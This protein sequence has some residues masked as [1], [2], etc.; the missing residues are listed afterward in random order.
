MSLRPGQA[1]FFFGALALEF[2]ALVTLPIYG[3]LGIAGHPARFVSL[4][5]LA[6]IGYLVAVSLYRRFAS[7]RALVFWGVAILLRVAVFSAPPGDDFWRYLWEGKIQLRG[8]NPYLLNPDHLALLP[9]RDMVWEKINHRDFAAIYPPG[10]ELLFAALVRF[11]SSPFVFKAVFSLADLA[12]CFFLVQLN[13]GRYSA[14]VW[15]AWHPAVVYSFAGAAHFDSL[16]I[17]AL[18]A[19]MMAL[20]RALAPNEKRVWRW[21]IFSAVAL[22]LAIALKT[23]PIFLLPVW[24]FALGR[25]GVVLIISAL[26]PWLLS[27]CYGGLAVVSAPL[28]AFA[29]VTRFND[30]VWWAIDFFWVDP[31]QQNSRYEIILVIA[32]CLIAFALRKDWRRAALWVLGAALLLSP[33]LHPWYVTW[34][35]PLACWRKAYAWTVLSLSSVI[36][37]LVWE[38]GPFW[39]AWEMSL[40]LRLLILLPPVLAGFLS[41]SRRRKPLKAS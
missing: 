33:V 35:L 23:V 28:A 36:A 18:A 29:R 12:T 9:F 16:M 39:K 27:L 22:G 26:I 37:L 38:A 21:S 25:R 14:P 24:A 8:F 41:A 20:D 11:S 32:V 15:Y 6:G 2:V 5:L 31:R 19:A 7:H 1:A 30:L 4:F 13:R 34:I 3:D 17:C 10:A 40:P